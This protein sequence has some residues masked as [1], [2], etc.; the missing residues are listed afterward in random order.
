MLSARCCE[1]NVQKK[2]LRAFWMFELP[3]NEVSTCYCFNGLTSVFGIAADN[4]IWLV[5]R[6]GIISHLPSSNLTKPITAMVCIP[7]DTASSVVIQGNKIVAL[8][9]L[10]SIADGKYHHFR[11]N[12]YLEE[13]TEASTE[14][15]QSIRLSEASIHPAEVRSAASIFDKNELDGS[16][17]F[18]P[19]CDSMQFLNHLQIS[20]DVNL[21]LIFGSHASF[22]CQ[23]L[24]WVRRREQRVKSLG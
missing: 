12:C 7:S 18:L 11:C 23:H 3:S 22:G 13:A 6:H 24:L 2:Q 21:V 19:Y 17:T 9:L 4:S 15:K 8:S 14:P 10:L 20:P 5:N 1:S 16:D